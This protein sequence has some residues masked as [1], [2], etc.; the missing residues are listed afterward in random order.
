MLIIPISVF[1]ENRQRLVD[2]LKFEEPHSLVILNSTT[3]SLSLT[4]AFVQDP[5]FFWAFG[6]QEPGAIGLIDIGNNRSYMVVERFN[7]P[8]QEWH[9]KGPTTRYELKTPLSVNSV[10]YI[11]ELKE[12]LYFMSSHNDCKQILILAD[13]EKELLHII[14]PFLYDYSKLN[15][16]ISYLID[17]KTDKE[18]KI[19][20]Y[21]AQVLESSLVHIMKRLKPGMSDKQVESWF[22]FYVKYK[23]D[24]VKTSFSMF[25]GYNLV[26]CPADCSS[27]VCCTDKKFEEGD[28]CVVDLGAGYLGY[29]ISLGAVLP[30]SE[31]FS[32]PQ[33]LAYRAVLE[34]RNRLQHHLKAYTPSSRVQDVAERYLLEILIN[35]LHVLY[36][37][38][39]G[40]K[41]AGVG[42][43]LI[44]HRVVS[45]TDSGCEV[46]KL[47]L[48]R[49][50]SIEPGCYFD[51]RGLENAFNTERLRPY[52]K[53]E[54]RQ[55]DGLFVKV[56][57]PVLITTHGAKF[58]SDFNREDT[59]IEKLRSKQP[60]VKFD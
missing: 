30:V 24:F 41:K 56:R 1:I 59:I 35:D 52:I 5:F 17:R 47:E 60:S 29:N 7:R 38:V 46:V 18:V 13:Q 3:P 57:D 11:D 34:M 51:K 44:P 49:V 33:L 23:Y 26:D 42:R 10:W 2:K 55:F 27:P 15:P 40:A 4:Q 48:G 19:L 25:G 32:H 16:V 45:C 21:I 28:L 20:C 50:Y 43:L 14:S 22:D 39:N 36:G 54:I 53:N 12:F 9:G 31:R 37:S 58:L 6:Y 8:N